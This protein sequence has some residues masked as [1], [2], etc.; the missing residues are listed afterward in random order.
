M[1]RNRET[2]KLQMFH[3]IS[4]DHDWSPRVKALHRAACAAYA[5]FCELD[6]LDMREQTPPP[7]ATRHETRQLAASAWFQVAELSEAGCLA[8]AEWAADTGEREAEEEDRPIE[9]ADFFDNPDQVRRAVED[10][11]Y[12]IK[13]G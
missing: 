6:A 4:F 1:V 5:A 10:K 12:R 7:S 11:T 3:E 13:E 9:P 2:G 8:L